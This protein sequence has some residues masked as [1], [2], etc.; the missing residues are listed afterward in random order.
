MEGR[1]QRLITWIHKHD[2]C[3]YFLIA[4]IGLAVIL[5]TFISLFWLVVI[6]ALH[7]GFEIIK[8][9]NETN[10]K[11]IL[12]KKVLWELKLDI[13]LIF[14]SF[15]IHL[16]MGFVMGVAGI[17]GM[18]R[19]GAGAARAGSATA[20]A[21]SATARTIQSGARVAP[22]FVII[23]R[24]IRAGLMML[25]EAI[26]VL[27]GFFLGDKTKREKKSSKTKKAKER[28]WSFGDWFTISLGAISII[29]ILFA[30]ILTE[31]NTYIRVMHEVLE[32]L[33]P[34]P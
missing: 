10:N 23:Q 32:E 1:K 31:H 21:T 33:R 5:S 13:A 11:A 18:S 14:F 17:G 27:R 24:T 2:D 26:L 28:Q 8:I 22:R 6:V 34:F 30:P 15:V 20:R 9:S 25:D 19:L 29:L 7:A 4:Y 3:W 16:Y 12:L